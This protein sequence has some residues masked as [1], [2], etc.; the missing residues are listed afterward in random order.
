MVGETGSGKTTQ[1]AHILSHRGYFVT[2][3]VQD[4]AIR[5]LLRFTSDEEENCC[6]YTATPCGCHVGSEAC[7]R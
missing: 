7:R 1:Y 4:T 6:M 3:F 5:C 2:G